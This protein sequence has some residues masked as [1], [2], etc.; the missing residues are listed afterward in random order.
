MKIIR[1]KG[2]IVKKFL[3]CTCVVLCGFALIGCGETREEAY[4]RG[5]EDA[6]RAAEEILYENLKPALIS[7]EEN[8]SRC[9][10]R[11]NEGGDSS[12][13]NFRS[14]LDDLTRSFYYDPFN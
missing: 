14:W 13:F 12:I 8:C 1:E 6:T 7:I 2:C 11:L 4:R 3:S 9:F 10:D 5:F